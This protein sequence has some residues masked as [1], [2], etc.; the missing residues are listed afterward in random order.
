MN[1]FG[2]Q[3]STLLKTHE[4]RM[5]HALMHG[6]SACRHGRHLENRQGRV[7]VVQESQPGYSLE[8]VIAPSC[9]S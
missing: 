7:S 2:A 9:H 4:P 5:N 3:E 8:G 6:V 1:K